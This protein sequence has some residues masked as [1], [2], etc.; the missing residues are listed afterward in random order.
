MSRICFSRS[1]TRD[2]DSL[3]RLV[4]R[5]DFFLQRV[6][7]IL[8]RS[9]PCRA[10]A[11]RGI[12]LGK[13]EDV[14]ASRRG[15]R[16]R[17]VTAAEAMLARR[18]VRRLGVR[19][20]ARRRR[21]RACRGSDF[22]SATCVRISLFASFASIAAISSADGTLRIWPVFRRFMLLPMNADLFSR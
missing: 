14:L 22:Q 12:G 9:H 20:A 6:D 10:P 21:R 15:R 5:G 13:L 19:A 17:R 2:C 11:L 4:L 7:A 8:R 18:D 16:G 3:Q 1:A